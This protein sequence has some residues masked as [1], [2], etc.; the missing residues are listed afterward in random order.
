M[1]PRGLPGHGDG[2]SAGRARA[3]G[4]GSAVIIRA[5]AP[6][7]PGAA[8]DRWPALRAGLLEGVNNAIK[9]LG[10]QYLARLS[11]LAS[12][13]L[14]LPARDA[15]ALR[16]IDAAESIYQKIAGFQT[17]R[18]MEVLEIVIV[19]LIFVSIVLPFLGLG[20]H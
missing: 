10:D 4:R 12:Q 17:T 16:K 13:R 9:L 20:G 5:G 18:R 19:A 14:H 8:L 6:L 15:S 3:R 2:G 1:Q 7:T 11:R